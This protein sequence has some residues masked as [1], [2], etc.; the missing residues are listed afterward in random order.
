VEIFISNYCSKLDD[1]NR[2]SVPAA[3]RT[4]I[5]RKGST[6]VYGYCSFINNAIEV[7]TEDRI[8]ELQ[9][10]IENLDIFS[11]ERD[12]LETSVLSGAEPL[13]IDNKGRVMISDRLLE[14]AGIKKE[15]VF[16]GKGRTFEIWANEKFNLHYKKS[17]EF[18]VSNRIILKPK[19]AG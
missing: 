10:F 11:P 18:A 4:I 5:E 16:V 2:L 19:K 7:C 15:A 13:N 3:Y 14:F 1:K 8:L 6:A 9:H 12:A 17:R